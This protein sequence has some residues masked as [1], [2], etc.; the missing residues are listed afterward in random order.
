M[1]LRHLAGAV[2][3]ACALL[4]TSALSPLSAAAQNTGGQPDDHFMCYKVKA[5]SLSILKPLS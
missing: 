4:L 1:P 3:A 5:S 2:S